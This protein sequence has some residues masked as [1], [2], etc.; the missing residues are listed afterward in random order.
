MASYDAKKDAYTFVFRPFTALG[1]DT[2]NV[3]YTVHLNNDIKKKNCPNPK[4]CPGAF[5][6]LHYTYYEWQFQTDTNF[7]YA[8]P[9]VVSVYPYADSTVPRNSIVQ[10]NFN[11]VMDPTAVQGVLKNGS[12]VNDLDFTNIIFSTTT[13][14]GEWKITNGYKTVEF[15]SD[16]GCGQN[17]W[18]RKCIVCLSV[19]SQK[20]V[21]IRPMP[22]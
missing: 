15:V 3:W 1:N 20:I 16:E 4:D 10:I 14:G 19:A 5:D 18:A 7:D 8:P 6:G 21:L 17:S 2:D 13:M 12:D 9:Y 11:E 22:P